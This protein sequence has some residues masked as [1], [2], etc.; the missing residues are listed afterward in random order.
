MCEQSYDDMPLL[1]DIMDEEHV[2][3]CDPELRDFARR[4]RLLNRI[5]RYRRNIGYRPPHDNDR[6][7]PILEYVSDELLESPR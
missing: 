2:Q 3:D 4:L 7:S 6:L 1:I 5:Y